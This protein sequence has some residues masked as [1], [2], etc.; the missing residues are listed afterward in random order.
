MGAGWKGEEE[1]RSFIANYF[2]LLFR[3]NGGHTSQLLLNAVDSRI[4]ADMNANLVKEFTREVVKIA[5][6]SIG[7][8]KAPGPDRMPSVF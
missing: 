4:S 6:V 2:T 5:L 7:D 8:F 1:K 3:S